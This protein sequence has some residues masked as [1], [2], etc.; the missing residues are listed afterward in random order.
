MCDYKRVV[1]GASASLPHTTNLYETTMFATNTQLS[2]IDSAFG[3][4][5]VIADYDYV[6]SGERLIAL[7]ATAAAIIVGVITYCTTA[8]QLFWL[9]HKERIITRAFQT[10]I[11]AAD[12]AGN[13][14]YAGRDFRRFMNTASERIMDRV[15][16]SLIA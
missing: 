3:V 12:F 13:C 14:Y 11:I 5:E 4:I 1:E 6:E 9:E 7:I 2:I 10:V 15:Y 8:L 16:Y